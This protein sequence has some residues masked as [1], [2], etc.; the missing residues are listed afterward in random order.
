VS[1]YLVDT[2]PLLWWAIDPHQ[3]TE[4]ARLILASGHKSV[5]VSHASAWEIAIKESRGKLSLPESYE[6]LFARSRFTQLPMTLAHIS[7]IKSL[8]HIHGD[9]FDRM[10]IAQAKVERLVLITRDTEMQKYDV[11]TLAA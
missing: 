5:F 3:L 7:Q 9:P 11:P 8:P 10:L 2:H 4:A 1:G 6:T